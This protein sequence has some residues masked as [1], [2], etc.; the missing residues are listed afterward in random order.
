MTRYRTSSWPEVLDFYRDLA[1]DPA[2]AIQ[3]MVALVEF[4]ASSRYAPSLFPCIAHDSL[5]IGRVPDFQQ[6]H[7]ELRI[8]FDPGRRQFTFTHVQRAHDP[9]PWSRECEAN[10]WEAT[11]ERLFH[12]R[13][14]WFHE[15]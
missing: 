5:V 12:K 11:L 7:N 3:P 6:G 4:L 8:R 9:H 13:L 15:G 10:E 14:H 1:A 2:C